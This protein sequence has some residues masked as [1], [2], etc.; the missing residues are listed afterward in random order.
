M[1][2][3]DKNSNGERSERQES[4]M[5]IQR[6]RHQHGGST[7]DR[8]RRFLRGRDPLGLTAAG[9]ALLFAICAGLYG[10]VWRVSASQSDLEVAALTLGFVGGIMLIGELFERAGAAAGGSSQVRHWSLMTAAVWLIAG[11][12]ILAA[13]GWSPEDHGV[14]ANVSVAALTYGVTGFA[15]QGLIRLAPNLAANLESGRLRTSVGVVCL[16][17]AFLVQLR[18]ALDPRL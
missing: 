12:V 14:V 3:S 4:E 5:G 2:H 18:L 10:L 16:I 1:C 7:L 6:K 8:A 13:L 11:T 9:L 15:L 17:V